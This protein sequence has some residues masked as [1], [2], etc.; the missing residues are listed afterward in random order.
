VHVGAA[1]I[2]EDELV[3]ISGLAATGYMELGVRVCTQVPDLAG[4]TVDF[5]V[6]GL[7]LAQ[8]RHDLAV[9]VQGAF[10]ARMGDGPIPVWVAQSEG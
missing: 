4:I 6:A 7:G 10:P 8:R 3:A 1:D 2:P 9:S 5:A